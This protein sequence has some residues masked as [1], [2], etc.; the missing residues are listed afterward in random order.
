MGSQRGMSHAHFVNPC[1]W[2]LPHAKEKDMGG[3][4][5]QRE[6]QVKKHRLE[7]TRPCITQ[8]NKK[9]NPKHGTRTHAL[10]FPETVTCGM[11]FWVGYEAWIGTQTRDGNHLTHTEPEKF[12]ILVSL[13]GNIPK[14]REWFCT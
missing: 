10:P 6:T 7:E 11:D 3:Q 4:G 13:R 5:T 8:E 2:P 14:R 1:A 9:Q 12:L